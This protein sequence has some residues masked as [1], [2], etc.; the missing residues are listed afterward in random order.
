MAGTV[1][2]TWFVVNL[3]Q[4]TTV[5]SPV[6]GT[7]VNFE[8]ERGFFPHVGFKLHILAPGQPNCYY[9]RETSQEGCLVLSGQCTALIE[10]QTIGLDR[11]DFVYLGPG[12][13][14]VFVGSGDREC[15][16]AL[17]GARQPLPKISYPVSGDARALGAG[18]D[19]ETDDPRTA[20][21]Q[22]PGWQPSPPPP[23]IPW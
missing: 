8:P 3:T 21:A 15:V 11:G 17:F 4:A 14:H 2:P 7:R 16:L 19:V 1:E 6:F 12:T 22:L 5:Q 20:Y 9:H 18:V 10:G 13:T 23:E